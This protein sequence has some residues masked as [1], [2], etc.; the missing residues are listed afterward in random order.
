MRR[1][2]LHVLWQIVRQALAILGIV[3]TLYGGFLH[4]INNAAHEDQRQPADAI[5]V[6]GGGVAGEGAPSPALVARVKHAVMLYREGYAPLIALTGGAQGDGPT[7]AEVAYRI[8]RRMGTP[9]E[10]L[11]IEATSQTTQQN[12]TAIAPLLRARGVQSVI[13]VTSPFH[14]LRSR[15]IVQGEG[16]TA[17][18]SPTPQDPAERRP[19]YR[20]YYILR[21]SILILVHGLFGI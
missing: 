2:A 9:E 18:V 10:A 8:A 7:E 21:E 17:W 1:S 12:V 19:W 6:M 20:I 16:F 14:T 15:M 13:V 3:C 4:T 5:L 11:V